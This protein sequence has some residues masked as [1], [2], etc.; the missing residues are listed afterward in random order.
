[1]SQSLYLQWLSLKEKIEYPWIPPTC[2]NYKEIGHILRNCH[3]LTPMW[4]PKS[5]TTTSQSVPISPVVGKEMSQSSTAGPISAN[6]TPHTTTDKPEKVIV[7]ME[8]VST[9]L[10]VVICPH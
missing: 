8:P 10:D 4:L 9:K 3:K 6:D 5:T 2:T 7:S 1:M